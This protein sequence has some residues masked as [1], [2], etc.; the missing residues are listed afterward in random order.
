MI[1]HLVARVRTA[2]R[3]LLFGAAMVVVH[4][5]VETYVDTL[6]G[7]GTYASR[8]LPYRDINE[9]W[10][11]GIIICLIVMFTRYARASVAQQKRH[12]A[13]LRASEEQ[14]QQSNRELERANA[15]LERANAELA[16]AT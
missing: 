16:Q 11:R 1:G 15:E 7:M 2:D 10:M 13:A 6:V 12:V 8:L 9:L 4:W 14:L 5:V 3:L